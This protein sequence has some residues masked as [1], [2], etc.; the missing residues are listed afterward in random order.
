M[1]RAGRIGSAAT[2]LVFAAAF[3]TLAVAPEKVPFLLTADKVKARI[4]HIEKKATAFTKK[5][6]VMREDILK[7]ASPAHGAKA[8][9]G[10]KAKAEEK[11][12]REELE[13]AGEKR[14]REKTEELEK[15]NMEARNEICNDTVLAGR[16]KRFELVFDDST[17]YMPSNIKELCRIDRIS[18]SSILPINIY[19]AVFG[20]LAALCG[21]EALVTL[22]RRK[23]TQ[24]TT[25]EP[26][27]KLKENGS[28]EAP[29]QN[30]HPHPGGVAP[31]GVRKRKKRR[32]GG[33]APATSRG[34]GVRKKKHE[35][36]DEAN[37]TSG[38]SEGK[39]KG[40]RRQTPAT[41]TGDKKA[42]EEEKP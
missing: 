11:R 7:P 28:E 38:A 39:H 13:K 5:T 8:V 36:T 18:F 26:A 15:L 42:E 27:E 1:G 12:R 16:S 23:K 6:E 19:R 17:Y 35:A 41:S 2:S 14:R 33:E 21:I 9:R 20:A 34:R 10:R 37:A 31:Q 25:P 30:A 3:A 40:G 32:A 29:A 24:Q 4:E 22:F